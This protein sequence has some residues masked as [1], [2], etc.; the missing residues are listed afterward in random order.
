LQR[1]LLLVIAERIPF[2][3]DVVGVD[4]RPDLF[5]VMRGIAKEPRLH[6]VRFVQADLLA[7]DFSTLGRFDTVTALRVIEHFT[8]QE[9]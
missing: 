5:E 4:I 3:R 7:D 9:M 1:F 8:E 6:Q 2:M